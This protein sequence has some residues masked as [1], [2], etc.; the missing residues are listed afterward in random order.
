M[1]PLPPMRCATDDMAPPVAEAAAGSGFGL[2]VVS[3]VVLAPLTLAIA[4]AGTPYFELLVIAGAAVL[5]TEWRTM[6]A[7][8]GA[9]R[10]LWWGLGILYV[11]LPCFALVWLR[12]DVQMGRE[13]LMWLFAVVWSADTGA[14]LAGRAIGGPKM[15]P[16]IS[17]NK[18]WAGLIGGVLSAGIVGAAV[19]AAFA[20]E[21]GLTRP[22]AAAG[23]SAAIGFVAEMGD[24]LESWLKR[25]LA[26]KDS[27]RLIPGHGGLFD[28]VDGL[29]AAAIAS[30]LIQWAGAGSM[31]TWF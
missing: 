15:A 19:A 23:L 18:T 25:R 31:L 11:A 28:R 29:L 26:V 1:T 5:L 20:G 6:T 24:L 13:T 3:A 8:V 14:Y 2:R 16:K 10:V 22:L 9:G 12:T 30:A 17:P 7:G 4:Y 21:D 27:G